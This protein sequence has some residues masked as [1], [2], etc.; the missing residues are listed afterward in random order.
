MIAFNLT[1][2]IT[3]SGKTELCSKCFAIHKRIFIVRYAC[4][5]CHGSQVCR[6]NLERRGEVFFFAHARY[7][8]IAACNKA[9][10]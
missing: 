4:C 7:E 1:P 8:N 10:V 2:P 5:T 9:A 3:D 6:G